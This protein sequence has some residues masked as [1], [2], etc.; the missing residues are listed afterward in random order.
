MMDV[1][2]ISEL[3]VSSIVFEYRML[4]NAKG[5]D[6]NYLSALYLSLIHYA[7]LTTAREISEALGE[8]KTA[9]S[10]KINAMIRQGLILDEV[11]ESDRRVH[12]LRIHPDHVNLFDPFDDLDRRVMEKAHESLSS[13]EIEGFYKVMRLYSETMR[14]YDE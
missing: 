4:R 10:K 8:D 3:T 6:V 5:L 12:R 14:E 7:N 1:D 2:R 9:V 11:D 13:E